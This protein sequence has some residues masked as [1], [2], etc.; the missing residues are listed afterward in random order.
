MTRPFIPHNG[1]PCP[2]KPDT[3][4]DV[5]FRDGSEWL[6]TPAH[7][8]LPYRKSDENWWEHKGPPERNI[9]AYRISKDTQ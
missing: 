3:L 8:W 1:G 2:V 5:Q 4:V 6:R 7:W 9:T